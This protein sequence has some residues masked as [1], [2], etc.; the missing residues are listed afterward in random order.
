MLFLF[1][2]LSSPFF[3]F[4]SGGARAGRESKC[5]VVGKIR[6]LLRVLLLENY[7]LEIGEVRLT[8]ARAKE[9]AAAAVAAEAVAAEAAREAEAALD[10]AAA[11]AAALDA[12]P[13]PLLPPPRPPQLLPPRTQ[14]G[15][16]SCSPGSSTAQRRSGGCTSTP[17][18]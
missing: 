17:A 4:E 7:A 5:L 9:A 1:L 8:T 2:F 6:V 16:A 12:E 10:A 14:P 15:T 18:G 3:F 13:Q 11:A